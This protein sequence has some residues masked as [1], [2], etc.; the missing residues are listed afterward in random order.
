MQSQSSRELTGSIEVLQNQAPLADRMRPQTLDEFVGQE[1]LV[2]QGKI[3]RTVIQQDKIPSMIFW[4]PPGSGKTTLARIIA[5][6][7]NSEFIQISA[8]LAGVK[9][10]RKVVERSKTLR[11]PEGD[12]V[13]RRIPFEA[14]ILRSA[15][16][17]KRVIL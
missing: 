14:E 17:D 11:H 7:T 2:G 3:L 13:D 15:Q 1:H 12:F 9:D 6:V 16:N 8:V 10:I 4:G 5:K